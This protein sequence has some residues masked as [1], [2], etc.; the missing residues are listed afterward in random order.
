MD[1][2]PV[3]TAIQIFVEDRM[4]NKDEWRGTATELLAELEDMANF[5]DGKIHRKSL[6]KTPQQLTKRLNELRNNF[7][8]FGII[9]TML[10]RTGRSR[11]ISIRKAPENAVTVVTS[12]EDDGTGPAQQS[13]LS[14]ES[15][16]EEAP[17]ESQNDGDDTSDDVSP[18]PGNALKDLGFFK[19]P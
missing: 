13:L 8:E 1:S 16:S 18:P 14:Q 15:S 19:N 11:G 10:P 4:K 5:E 12:S 7:A 6:P 3:A 9:V 17:S 2:N